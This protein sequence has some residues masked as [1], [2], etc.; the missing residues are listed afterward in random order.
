MKH[1][2]LIHQQIVCVKQ[3][4]SDID[5][6]KLKNCHILRFKINGNENKVEILGR[7]SK[8]HYPN[9]KKGKSGAIGF[10]D[11]DDLKFV[12]NTEVSIMEISNV[13]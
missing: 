3:G 10:Y 12:E 8:A 1:Q 13:C 2:T 6:K 5:P 9:T 7:A 11:A 4:V